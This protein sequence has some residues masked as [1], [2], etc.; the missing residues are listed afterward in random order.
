MEDDRREDGGEGWL[1]LVVE[2]IDHS[3][4]ERFGNQEALALEGQPARCLREEGIGAIP[5]D[6][7]VK[8]QSRVFQEKR[9]VAIA[10]EAPNTSLTAPS[11]S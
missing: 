3:I 5:A 4:R 9:D 10:I 2:L 6:S 11:S 7:Q 8:D 1:E